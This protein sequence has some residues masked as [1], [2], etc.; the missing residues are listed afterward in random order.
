MTFPPFFF[1]FLFLHSLLV[2]M[3]ELRR[4]GSFCLFVCVCVFFF[5]ILFCSSFFMN[6]YSGVWTNSFLHVRLGFSWENRLFFWV[7][8]VFCL[9]LGCPEKI[10]QLILVYFVYFYSL[11]SYFILFYFC[12]KLRKTQVYALYS[13]FSSVI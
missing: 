9:F 11:F 13:C 5:L 8:F 12:Q 6:L 4:D 2:F 10:C 1:F 7:S 3:Q